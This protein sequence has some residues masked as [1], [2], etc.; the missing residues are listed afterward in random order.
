MHMS[1]KLLDLDD[2]VTTPSRGLC[3][4]P[5]SRTMPR[6]LRP[7]DLVAKQLAQPH[8]VP[9]IALSQRVTASAQLRQILRT[10]VES[11]PPFCFSRN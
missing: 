8:V 10:Q 7:A 6:S 3:Q 4:L 1:G 11:K 9:A 5:P 2:F